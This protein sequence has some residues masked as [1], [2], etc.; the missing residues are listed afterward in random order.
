MGSDKNNKMICLLS[1]SGFYYVK[2]PRTE[3]FGISLNPIR[4]NG[5]RLCLPYYYV[6][7]IFSDGAT[8]LQKVCNLY[9]NQKFSKQPRTFF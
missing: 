8:S 7:P 6:P 5:G 9:S 1:P 2:K 4:T 3:S